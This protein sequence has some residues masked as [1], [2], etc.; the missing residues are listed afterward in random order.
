MS[1]ELSA[2]D[3]LSFSSETGDDTDAEVNVVSF[4]AW[5][6][7]ETVSDTTCEAAS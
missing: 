5:I 6:Q 3:V 1:P 7:R 2:D 4:K